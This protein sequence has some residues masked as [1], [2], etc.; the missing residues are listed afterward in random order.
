MSNEQTIINGLKEKRA[1]IEREFINIK[2]ELDRLTSQMS[3]YKDRLEAVDKVI[4]EFNGHND[5]DDSPLETLSEEKQKKLSSQETLIDEQEVIVDGDKDNKKD[6]G[7]TNGN[8]SDKL[9]TVGRSSNF[10]HLVREQS[11][12][13][14]TLFTRR[15]VISIMENAYPELKDNI[16]ENTLSGAMR[17]LVD[18]GYAKVRYKATGTSSQ[19]YEKI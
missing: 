16:N 8:G 1:S 12:N 13:L 3:A 17:S 9:I 6:E 11:K 14:P 4:S 15:D 10:R 7:S 18:K 5:S 2:E 19:I